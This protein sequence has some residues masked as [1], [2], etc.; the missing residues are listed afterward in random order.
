MKNAIDEIGSDRVLFSSDYPFEDME[1][2]THW[3]DHAEIGE[4][5]REKIGRHNAHKLFKL[6]I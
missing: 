2:A 5:D 4:N 3:F 1:E 6:S